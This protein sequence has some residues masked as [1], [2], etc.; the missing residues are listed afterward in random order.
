MMLAH[1]SSILVPKHLPHHIHVQ[2]KRDTVADKTKKPAHAL[3]S[4]T[5]SPLKDVRDET[6]N[7]IEH[8]YLK[9]L[10]S[11]TKAHIETACR[12]SGLSRSRLYALLK[13]YNISY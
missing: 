4:N 11:Q 2:V 3:S 5:L 10:M 8:Q 13:K 6:I 7:E 12:I 9:E 1:D